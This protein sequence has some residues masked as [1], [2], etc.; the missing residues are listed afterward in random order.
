M[1]LSRRFR[2]G[3]LVVACL[4]L[5]PCLVALI[6]PDYTIVDLYNASTAVLV[7]ELASPAEERLGARVA[8]TIKGEPPEAG[9]AFLFSE[10]RRVQD[11]KAWLAEVGKGRPAVFFTGID[12][13][14][15]TGYVEIGCTWARCTREPDGAWYLEDDDRDLET[16]WGGSARTLA[17]AVRYVRDDRRPEFPVEEQVDWADERQL[18]QLA[19]PAHGLRTIDLGGDAGRC[20]LVLSAAGDRAFRLGG[21]EAGTDLSGTLGLTSASR[22]LTAADLTDDGRTDLVTWDGEGVAVLIQGEDGRFGTPVRGPALAGVTSLAT[23][24]L[25]SGRPGLVAGLETGIALLAVEAGGGLVSLP[26]P[27]PVLGSPDL[28]AR[29][30]CLAADVDDDGQ[31]D[32]LRLYAGGLVFWAGGTAPPTMTRLPLPAEPRSTVFGDFDG[33]GQLDLFV[34]GGKDFA[35]LCRDAEGGWIRTTAETGELRVAQPSDDEAGLVA[36]AALDLNGDGRQGI[37]VF[38]ARAAPCMFFNRGFACFGLS[39]RMSATYDGEPDFR[40]LGAGVQAGT[41]ADLDGDGF[42][43]ALVVDPTGGVWAVRTATDR[44]RRF[45]LTLA[46]PADAVAPLSVAVDQRGRPL[47]MYV[48]SPARAVTLGL[49]KAGPTNLR[50]HGPDGQAVKQQVV[51]AKPTTAILTPEP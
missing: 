47:G 8:H 12:D 28:G 16:V 41:V 32:L 15:D 18:G 23:I 11:L 36:A 24:R 33:D 7:L 25:D 51:V 45:R 17:K 50:W 20:L 5:P 34:L 31:V 21:P 43:D 2:L 46:L 35:L 44:P 29:G 13:E 6:N 27:P 9:P 4:L 37:A 40:C 19:G 3:L 38:N 1:H 49:P 14:A 48:V 26:P 22:D 39:R 10:D 42:P 30:P